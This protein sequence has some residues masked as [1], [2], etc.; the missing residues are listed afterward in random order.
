MAAPESI[1]AASCRRGSEAADESATERAVA[2]MNVPGDGEPSGS[3]LARY[4]R[5]SSP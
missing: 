4:E 3:W 2:T 1:A 5:C